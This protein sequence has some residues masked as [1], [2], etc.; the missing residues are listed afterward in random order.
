MGGENGLVSLELGNRHIAP[1][2]HIQQRDPPE[3]DPSPTGIGAVGL[4]WSPRMQS[5]SISTQFIAEA[6]R[7]LVLDF[8]NLREA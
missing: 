3:G 1:A 8:L 4:T 6:A 7:I 5:G 2:R